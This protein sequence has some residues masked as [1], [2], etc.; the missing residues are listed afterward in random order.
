MPIRPGATMPVGDW[1]TELATSAEKALL[2]GKLIEVVD[3]ATEEKP[4]KKPK[5]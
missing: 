5:G 4:E 3:M 2:D 1:S